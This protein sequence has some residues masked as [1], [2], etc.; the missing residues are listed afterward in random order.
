MTRERLYTASTRGKEL[1]L[2]ATAAES[3]LERQRAEPH[4]SSVAAK[5]LCIADAA[6]GL[7]ACDKGSR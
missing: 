4:A 7:P 3:P 1:V 6:L 5:G 2:L